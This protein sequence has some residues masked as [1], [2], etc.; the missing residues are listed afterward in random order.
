MSDDAY[1]MW[2]PVEAEADRIERAV[3]GDL[4]DD[5]WHDIDAAADAGDDGR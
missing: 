3:L 1:P 4:G 2:D 5:D